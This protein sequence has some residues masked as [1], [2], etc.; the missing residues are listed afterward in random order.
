[1]NSA[2]KHVKS[3]E[4]A[5]N[6]LFELFL[7]ARDLYMREVIKNHM[8]MDRFADIFYHSHY[9]IDCELAECKNVHLTNLEIV[10]NV[11]TESPHLIEEF[12]LRKD[13]SPKDLSELMAL[14]LTSPNQ[15]TEG[16]SELS[17]GCNFSNEQFSILI[18]IIEKYEV[19]YPMGDES[20]DSEIRSLFDCKI[21]L[22]VQVTNVR[23]VAV[24]FDALLECN[25][26]NRDWQSVLEKGKFLMS[27]KTGKPITSSA[28]LSALYKV[29]LRPMAMYQ[30]IRKEVLKMKVSDDM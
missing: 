2:H 28:L 14:Y 21:G 29:K 5:Y 26:I 22:Q 23:K 9:Y 8:R 7:S 4:D 15:Y 10:R 18:N 25:L 24:L 3:E 11:F 20:V 12:L 19:F 13:F 30:N 27:R 1:M 17:F 6:E 16:N